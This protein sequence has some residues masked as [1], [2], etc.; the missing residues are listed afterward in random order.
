MKLFSKRV[1]IFLLP[2]VIII[3][4]WEYGLST[5]PNSYSIKNAQMEA[6]AG[7]IEALVLG[8]SHALRGVDPAYFVMKGYN[9]ANV[10]QSLYY[11]EQITLKYL[12][13]MHS[14]K[15]VL[16]DISYISLWQDVYK[17]Q[18]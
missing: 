5:I 9:A 10:S 18:A 2:V 4:L 1:L 12:D 11:D 3:A 14:L 16:M 8:G 15:L 13:K 17:R 7:Q 6:Q